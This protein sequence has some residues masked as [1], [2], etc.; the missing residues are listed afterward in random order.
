VLKP[1]CDLKDC[2]F[3]AS[4]TE[5]WQ[6]L[7][8]F[9]QNH[10][11]FSNAIIQLKLQARR[12]DPESNLTTWESVF[13]AEPIHF[14]NGGSDQNRNLIEKA[15]HYERVF[16]LNVNGKE[17][18]S[19]HF[20]SL[21]PLTLKDWPTRDEFI[22]VFA[23]AAERCLIYGDL[24]ERVRREERIRTEKRLVKQM[25][26]AAPVAMA[27]FDVDFNVLA[28][29]LLW[30]QSSELEK[31]IIT[32]K[33]ELFEHASEGQLFT[34]HLQLSSK[35]GEDL[36]YKIVVGPSFNEQG[37]LNALIVVSSSVQEIVKE[38]EL[39]VLQNKM[40]S[41][42]LANMSH[43]IRTPMN[44]VLGMLEML[45][46]TN[47]DIEQK[48][49]VETISNSAESLLVILN[50]ILDFSKIEAGKFDLSPV[51]FN[52]YDN[53]STSVKTFES[54]AMKKNLKLEFN[55]F[56]EKNLDVFADPV[57]VRQIINNFIS[58][59]IKFTHLGRVAVDVYV[60]QSIGQDLTRISIAVKDSGIGIPPS[61]VRELFKPFEQADSSTSRQFGGTG[62][63]L[64]ITKS[65]VEMM[66]GELSVSSE[67]GQGSTFTV[68]LDF[69]A[70]AE[71][72]GTQVQ[73]AQQLHQNQSRVD[74][75]KLQVLVA[76]DN[77]VNQQVIELML[78]ALGIEFKIVGN[79]LEAVN[80]V[81]N[82]TY[83][84]IFLDCQMPLMDGYAAAIEIKEMQKSQLIPVCPIV[85]LTA[86]VFA[87]EKEKCFAAGMDEF[88]TKPL[89]LQALKDFFLKYPSRH[90][91]EAM[92]LINQEQLDQLRM[93][94]GDDPAVA[95]VFFSKIISSF[96]SSVPSRVQDLRSYYV[97]KNLEELK[98]T[99][100]YLKSTFGNLGMI[101]LQQ[102]VMEI[103]KSCQENK[104]DNIDE[105]IQQVEQGFQP[106]LEE[107]KSYVQTHAA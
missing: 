86:H 54:V 46:T 99:A 13:V 15:I 3:H 14:I 92:K 58:N 51:W 106:H 98:K 40:K 48:E 101:L 7:K 100:H 31:L 65:L 6:D 1:L 85:A 9:L 35:D 60:H 26:R 107:L 83:D 91:E 43:E 28:K 33:N 53:I 4:Q 44:G 72:E 104:I 24:A 18:L 64:A 97:Q 16:P 63:G 41:S 80:E 42:F 68:N 102:S 62:L 30:S 25:I 89:T 74:N 61:K 55:Y 67:V 20:T 22:Q 88:L 105:K 70:K 82:K 32:K 93:V 27:M 79:G 56:A 37:H 12:Q 50:D 95:Q 45:R 96:E 34:T 10:W 94:A 39:A 36:Y 29:S 73:V 66:K 84:F 75:Q 38:K 23:L 21:M 78:G 57:R 5:N 8:S 90:K 103:E 69:K 87:S 52:L 49:F 19:L 77:L 59:A 17:N 76:E 11:A 47:L 81:K 71:E 2:V